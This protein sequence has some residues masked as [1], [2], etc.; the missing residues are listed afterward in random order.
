MADH[1][2]ISKVG[3]TN[4]ASTKHAIPKTMDNS[5]SVFLKVP[6]NGSNLHKVVPGMNGQIVPPTPIHNSDHLSR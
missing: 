5:D 1:T 6:T 2:N 4:N 3:I